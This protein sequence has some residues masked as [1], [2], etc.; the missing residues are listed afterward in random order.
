[1]HIVSGSSVDDGLLAT[2]ITAA[3]RAWDRKC[4][5]VA[6]AIDY[7]ASAAVVNELLVGQIDYEGQRII[8]Y[9]HKPIINS[10][11]SFGYQADIVSTLYT[12]DPSRVEAY[13]PK[14]TA[15][16]TNMALDFPSSCK[17]VLSY[18]GGVGATLNDL[19]DDLVEAV[20]ILAIRFYREAESGLTDQIGIADS[21]GQYVY[22]KAW[23][24]RVKELSEVY[25][26]KVGWRHSA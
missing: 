12:V 22:T 1:M 10:V 14:V 6:D 18:T 3:S 19:P 5:G 15:Y 17:V 9:P 16:P 8:C 2:L 23:P 26:R 24:V 11:Q 7:F 21:G 20:T 4:A 13:G 25:K